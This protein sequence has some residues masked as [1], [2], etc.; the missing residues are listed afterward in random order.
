MLTNIRYIL[1]TALR[2]R[3]FG[4]LMIGV[5]VCSMVAHLLGG[6]ALVETQEMTLSYVSAS[7]RLVIVSGLIVFACFH[8]RSAFDT[9]EIDMF[10]ARP[11]TR[12]SL[13]F[14]YWLGFAAVAT[15]LVMPTVGFVALQGLMDKTGFMLW[16]ISLLVECWLAVAVALFA[17]FALRSAVTSVLASIGFYVLGRMMGFFIITTKSAFLFD[18]QWINMVLTGVLKGVSIIMPRMDFFA[19]SEWLI[20]GIKNMPDY[21]W[22]I[23]QAGVFIPLLIF[24][25]IADFK[26]KQ[27]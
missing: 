6:T 7:S 14:S 20:Y 19:K 18:Q 27:F 23:M 12:A 9:K 15:L 17:S 24:A 8:V 1:L 22:G 13:V 4:A 2:D 16:A 21:Q 3:L 11:I 26:R 5:I 10:L 25:T